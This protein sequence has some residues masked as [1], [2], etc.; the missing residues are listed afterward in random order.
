MHARR[1]YYLK[2]LAREMQRLYNWSTLSLISSWTTRCKTIEMTALMELWFRLWLVVAAV[3]VS[4]SIH[5]IYPLY[6]SLSVLFVSISLSRSS[7]GLFT[8]SPLVISLFL[9]HSLLSISLSLS[10]KG[11]IM[12]DFVKIS[13]RYLCWSMI[14]KV[15]EPH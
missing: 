14:W 11:F 2:N 1:F 6:L 3:T 5:T 15:I 4:P 8:I 13:V 10:W 9:F 7:V 12:E